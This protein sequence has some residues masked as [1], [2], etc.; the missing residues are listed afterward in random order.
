M[1]VKTQIRKWLSDKYSRVASESLNR[2]KEEILRGVSRLQSIALLHQKTFSN[3][4]EIYRGRDIVLIGGGPTVNQF[5]PIDNCIYVG[6]NRACLLTNVKFDYLFTIDKVGV[7]KIY[8]S[9]GQYDCVKFVGDQNLGPSFQIPESKIAEMKNVH[10]YKTDAGLFAESH[11]ALDLMTEPLG[12]FNTAALQAMQFI[13]YTNPRR[14]YLVGMDCST[15]GHFNSLQGEKEQHYGR[16]QERGE[17]IN[18]MVRD[19]VK[20]WH[21]LKEFANQYYPDT[22]I[23]SVNP[24]G[25]RGLFTDI[26]Q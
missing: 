7:D 26:D 23:V 9:F 18:L 12:N 13:L 20:Y 22:E 4:K 15:A 1:W 19:Y 11:F 10:R 24:V 21:Q 8:P 3:Y 2:Q 25:L 14:V 16:L 17:N 5:K 6:L